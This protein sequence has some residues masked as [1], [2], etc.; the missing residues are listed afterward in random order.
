VA[1]RSSTGQYF[2]PATNG[3][4][5]S[6]VVA[7]LLRGGGEVNERVGGVDL[8]AERHAYYQRDRND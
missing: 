3:N 1:L 5:N 6:V 7:G 2:K 4:H 8:R